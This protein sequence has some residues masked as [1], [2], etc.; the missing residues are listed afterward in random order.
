MKFTMKGTR[1]ISLLCLLLSGGISV[2][3]GLAIGLNAKA[4]T[5][6][7]QAVYYGTRCLLEGHN[8]YKRG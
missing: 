1:S 5:L 4:P 2:W 7:F 3:W 8:P 6:D